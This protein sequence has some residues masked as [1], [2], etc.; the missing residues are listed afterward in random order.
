[1]RVIRGEV[2]LPNAVQSVRA[3]RIVI[4]ISDVTLADA[5]A[6]LLAAVEIP[7]VDIDS[8]ARVAFT[9]EDV[10]EGGPN[11]RLAAQAHVDVDGSGGFSPGDLLTTVH[12]A[13]PTSGDVDRLQVPVS[14]I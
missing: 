6:V 3:A 12:V 10:P 5:S 8:D 7:D 9:I 11:A 4:E 14:P 13:V 1:M 2:V